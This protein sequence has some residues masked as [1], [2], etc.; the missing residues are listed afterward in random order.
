MASSVAMFA[1]PIHTIVKIYKADAPPATSMMCPVIATLVNCLW[2]FAYGVAKQSVLLML[3]HLIGFCVA[4]VACM[5]LLHKASEEDRTPQ[6]KKLAAGLWVGLFALGA[7]LAMTTYQ[8]VLD[9]AVGI[10]TAGTVLMYLSPLTVLYAVCRKGED[11]SA[12]PLAHSV[13]TLTNATILVFYGLLI[14]DNLVWTPNVVGVAM[15]LVQLMT[16]AV[17]EIRA[18]GKLA[19][20]AAQT[21]TLEDGAAEPTATQFIEE[22]SVSKE[23][24]EENH[25]AV[26]A[27]EENNAAF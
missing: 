3:P 9:I 2:W 17:V 20:A 15:G 11:I 25:P 21:T 8:H 5:M 18:Q 14:H 10:A 23:P 1:A 26:I 13:T 19:K 24:M 12:M 22:A 16:T 4:S 7:C 6:A 27:V